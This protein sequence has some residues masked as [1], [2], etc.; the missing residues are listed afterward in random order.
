[1][2][3]MDLKLSGFDF[4]VI[5]GKSESPVYLWLHDELAD[6]QDASGLWGKDSW[7]TTQSIRND[8]GEDLI[9]V[10]TIGTAGEKGMDSAQVILNY[11]GTG[12]KFA[13][14]K[15]FGRKNLKAIAS[16]GL[17]LIEIASPEEFV[18]KSVELKSKIK[19]G[20]M[21]EKNGVL[22]FCQSIGVEP[23]KD[24][25][26]PV[27][28]RYTSCFSCSYT[29]N[30]FLKYNESPTVVEISGVDEPGFLMTDT[31]SAIALRK[32]GLSPAD[33][34]RTL[35]LCA[36]L[37]IEPASA[38]REISRA[39]EK[40]FPGIK[41]ILDSMLNNEVENI[42]PHIKNWGEDGKLFE[43][44]FSPWTPLKPLFADFGLDKDSGE[45]SSWWKK[46]N[47][48]FYILGVCPVFSLMTPE[49]GE[50]A[51]LE[52]LKL[53]TGIDKEKGFLDKLIGKLK[54]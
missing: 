7:E 27:V 10:L 40:E 14:G 36:K 20:V 52:F 42:P 39:G 8:L 12:D 38:A 49:I 28:H 30:T 15:V 9:Q 50:E 18:H 44:P 21:A 31:S 5:K 43:S 19:N 33:A 51:L 17:G 23:A 6:I 11:W 24:W 16:R 2:G 22:D 46:R 26:S 35:E 25:I 48:I 32:C 47:A 53:G 45:I 13:F 37:G 3:G 29:C 34:G 4:V 1:M 41:K 54:Y